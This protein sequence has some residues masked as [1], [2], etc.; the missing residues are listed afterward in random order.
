MV[1]HSQIWKIVPLVLIFNFLPPVEPLFLQTIIE[2]LKYVTSGDMPPGSKNS[3]FVHDPKV[4]F[5]MILLP[6]L[7]CLIA[8]SNSWIYNHFLWQFCGMVCLIS[9]IDVSHIESLSILD[10]SIVSPTS[11]F[12]IQC[13]CILIKR[14]WLW[15][16][17]NLSPIL[18]RSVGTTLLERYYSQ[19]VRIAQW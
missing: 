12:A 5:I 17:E 16:W 13:L 11:S 1:F 14:E 6:T 10:I 8:R 18:K 2:C 3:A 15:R 4:V 19:R 7:K 9:V